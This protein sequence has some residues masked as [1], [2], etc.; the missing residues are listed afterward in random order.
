MKGSYEI[1]KLYGGARRRYG[2]G[3]RICPKL[4]T[5]IQ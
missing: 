2:S 4:Y 1:K 3:G 5:T